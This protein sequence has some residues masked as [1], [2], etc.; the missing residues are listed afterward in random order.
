MMALNKR[1]DENSKNDAAD[2]TQA[3]TKIFSGTF[4]TGMHGLYAYAFS[5]WIIITLFIGVSTF[6]DADFYD[7]MILIITIIIII[8]ICVFFIPALVF[9]LA[10]MTRKQLV[11]QIRLKIIFMCGTIP[12]LSKI[13][14]PAKSSRRC[15]EFN[16]AIIDAT[17]DACVS[18]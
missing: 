3:I 11:E 18:W 10:V 16:K 15:F 2:G 14:T 13:P 1:G 12:D 6:F 7:G 17:K 8:F 9:Y 5:F 4:D